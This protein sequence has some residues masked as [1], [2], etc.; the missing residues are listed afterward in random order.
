[1]TVSNVSNPAYVDAVQEF[2]DEQYRRHERYWWRGANRYSLDPSR[3]TSFHAKTLGLAIEK[4]SGRALDVGAGEG[5]DAIRLAKLGYTVDAIELSSVACEKIEQFAH[6]EGVD[7]YVRNES[8]LS[9]DFEDEVYDIIVMNG[10]LHYV[11]DKTLLLRRVRQASVPGALHVVSLFSNITP[12]PAEHAAVPVFP[13]GER[14][15]VENFY[16]GDEFLHLGYV[17]GKPERSHPGF[18]DHAHSFINLI[19]RLAKI[20]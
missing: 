2:F 5:A 4:A 11:E 3:H 16:A 9:A 8:V 19:V 6:D 20:G 1:M 10:S 13:D 18:A 7:V 17:R 15:I 14:G 12:I